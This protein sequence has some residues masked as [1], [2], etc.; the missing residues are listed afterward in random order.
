MERGMPVSKPISAKPLTPKE[1]MGSVGMGLAFVLLY[2]AGQWAGSALCGYAVMTRVWLGGETNY[3]VI[4]GAYARFA[5]ARPQLIALV[6]NV[7]ALFVASAADRLG[8]APMERRAQTWRM[9][10]GRAALLVVCGAAFNIALTLG[11]SLLPAA[12]LESYNAASQAALGKPTLMTLLLTV[13]AAPLTEEAVFRGLVYGRFRRAMPKW[14]AILLSSGLFGLLHG[15]P[16][17]MAYAFVMGCIF[18]AVYERHGTLLAPVL[19]HMSFNGA[20]F[21]FSLMG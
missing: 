3:D 19:V 4:Y 11:I 1:R 9:P 16:L 17:W 7:T 15:Q 13:L 10:V 14:V 2:L 8:N 21:L 5:Q 12:W 18:C 20:S 6:G